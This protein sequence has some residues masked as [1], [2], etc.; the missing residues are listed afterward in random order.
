[1]SYER[2]AATQQNAI[3]EIAELMENPDENFEQ[4]QR[5]YTTYIHEPTT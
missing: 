2:L 3:N 1:M 5:F 4:L